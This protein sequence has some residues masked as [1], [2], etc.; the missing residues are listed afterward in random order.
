MNRLLQ[1]LNASF[2]SGLKF[3]TS[4]LCFLVLTGSGLV[5]AQDE[6]ATVD[7]ASQIVPVFSQRCLHCHGPEDQSGDF[8]IDDRD[9]TMGHIEP[10]DSEGS[11]LYELLVAEPDSGLM[12]PVDDGGPLPESEIQL[13]KVWIDQGAEWPEEITI[14]PPTAEQQQVVQE[15]VAKKKAEQDREKSSWLLLWEICGLLHPVFLHFPVAMIVG[16]AIF[17][18]LGFRGES[19]MSDAAY[20]CLCLGAIGSLFATASGWSFAI[21]EGYGGWEGGAIDLDKTIERHRWAGI[22]AT[23]LTVILAIGASVSRRND[24][25][26]AG[27]LWK[28]GLIALAALMG[29]VGHQ[30]GEMTHQGIHEELLDKAAIVS[31]NLVGRDEPEAPPLDEAEATGDEAKPGDGQAEP[32]ADDTKQA[33]DEAQESNDDEAAAPQT[34]GDQESP[35]QNDDSESG[36]TEDNASTDDEE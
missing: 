33:D 13:V 21:H 25:Y 26:G 14:E 17:A 23:I 4:F 16:G 28:L 20:Y 5:Q 9:A 7:F 31:D 34:D 10:G 11:Y 32:D 18:V 36:E 22:L 8:R 12:P 19:P 29:Y 30:G 35:E 6:A 24:P 15:A 3:S 27:T 1:E 2:R